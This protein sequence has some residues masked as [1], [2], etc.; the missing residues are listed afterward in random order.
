MVQIQ[1]QL[2]FYGSFKALRKGRLP[3][4]TWFSEDGTAGMFFKAPEEP[5]GL[6]VEIL[7]G[8]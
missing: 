8:P 3:L 1:C 6:H 5:V 2:I 7:V 4:L